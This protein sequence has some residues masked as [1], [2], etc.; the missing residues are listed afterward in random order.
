MEIVF[1]L[2]DKSVVVD[3]VFGSVNFAKEI[4]ANSYILHARLEVATIVFYG[5]CGIFELTPK[6]C[7]R[8]CKV[9]IFEESN[10]L[11]FGLTGELLRNN[12]RD[13]GPLVRR[14]SSTVANL[15]IAWYLKLNC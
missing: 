14:R 2:Q 5:S 9:S 13:L 4:L 10:E 7:D 12:R 6:Y 3:K 11:P 15:H 1:L 8:L